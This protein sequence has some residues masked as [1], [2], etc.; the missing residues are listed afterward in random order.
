M[1]QSAVAAGATLV[2]VAFAMSTFERWLD[3]RRRHEL[4]WAI[5][6]ALFAAGAGCL[7]LGA[8]S[9]WT[10]PTFR[11]FYLF[12][13]VINVPVLAL[14]TVYLLGGRRAGDRTALVVGAFAAFATG[15]IVVAP[16]HTIPSATALPQGSDV[17]GVLPRVL[18][19]VA[20]AGGAL[21][22]LGGAVWSAWRLRRGRRMW[23]NVVI[24]AGTLVLGAS[25]LLN[26]VLGEME[27][28]AVTLAVGVSIL[29]AGFLLAVTP[30]RRPA[31]PAVPAAAPSP[32][33]LVESGPRR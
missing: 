12:G 11:A 14:G 20:S 5:A 15:V 3:R 16:A 9:G 1:S 13:A 21:V 22:V 17:F 29:Y 25:G 28:F 10:L 8:S 26:S 27:A 4:A 23:A 19:A 31:P 18:A 6:L 33:T 24:A 30:A 2:A 32:P 7:W